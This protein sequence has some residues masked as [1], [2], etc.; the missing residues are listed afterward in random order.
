MHPIPDAWG[1]KPN[2]YQS[3]HFWKDFI[4]KVTM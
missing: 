3:F 1:A 2:N 4:L